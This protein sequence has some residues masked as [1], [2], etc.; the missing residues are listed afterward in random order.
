MTKYLWLL[1]FKNL[2]QTKIFKNESESTAYYLRI[3]FIKKLFFKQ[4]KYQL[5]LHSRIYG[6]MKHPQKQDVF[7][8]HQYGGYGSK[9]CT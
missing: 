8:K 7:V 9:V 2:R 5:N 3:Y 4:I 6:I 1:H